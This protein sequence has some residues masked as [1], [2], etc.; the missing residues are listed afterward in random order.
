MQQSELS[1]IWCYFAASLHSIVILPKGHLVQQLHILGGV[2]ENDCTCL[3]VISL[4]LWWMFIVIHYNIQC[5]GNV[6]SLS[7]GLF[8]VH[9][10]SQPIDFWHFLVNVMTVG[11]HS[12]KKGTAYSFLHLAID[13]CIQDLFARKGEGA[14][15]GK[16]LEEQKQKLGKYLKW[17]FFF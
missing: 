8:N 10:M 17:F 14:M 7:I 1:F 15:R 4:E 9:L 12:M 2:V 5:S 3:H 6:Y 16:F 11:Y 13:W